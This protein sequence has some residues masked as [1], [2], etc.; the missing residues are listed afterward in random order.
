M[1][2]DSLLAAV[3]QAVDDGDKERAAAATKAALDAGVAPLAIM[4]IGVTQGMVTIGEKFNIFEAFLPELMLAAEAGNA[5]FELV[6]PLLESEDSFATRGK[7]VLGTSVGDLHDIGKNMVGAVLAS[8]GFK[9][10]DLGVDVPPL[11][12]VKKAEEVGADIIGMSSLLTTSLPYLDDVIKYLNDMEL[13]DK[14]YVIVGGGP[15]T[16][17]FAKEIKADGYARLATEAVEL[18]SRLV[19]SPGTAPL[20]E[21]IIIGDLTKN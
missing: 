9:V 11:D 10:I 6:L 8:S 15:V 16:P 7:V 17:E 3:S 5:C 19:D 4:E 13:R 21:P 20:A 12:F 1:S 2:D 14:Y 18:C